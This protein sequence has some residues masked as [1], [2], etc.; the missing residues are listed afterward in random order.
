[1]RETLAPSL[2]EGLLFCPTAQKGLGV[3]VARRVVQLV[4]FGCGENAACDF[5]TIGLRPNA[6]EI[7]ADGG[8]RRDGDQ[9]EIG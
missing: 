1:M 4:H 8:I 5:A 9:R 3:E 2:H 6:F 7:D